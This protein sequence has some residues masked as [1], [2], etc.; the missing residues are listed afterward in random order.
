MMGKDVPDL[1]THK[2]G[3]ATLLSLLILPP[4]LCI[5]SLLEVEVQG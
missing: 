2:G 4:L 1:H 3:A 5:D